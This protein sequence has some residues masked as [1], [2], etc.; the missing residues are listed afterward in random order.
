MIDHPIPRST[1]RLQI[2]SAFTFA[3][4][5]ALV[6]YLAELG[7]SHAYLSPILKARRGS[8]H[9]YDTVDH[10][11][12]S[13]ELGGEEGFRRLAAAL[14]A[15]GM[16]ILLDIVPNHMGVGGDENDLWLDLLEWG[17]ASRYA[18]WFDVNWRP[19][20]PTL[21]GKVLVPFLASSYA[22]AL[23][24]DGLKLRFDA[25]AG[26]FAVWAEGAHKLPLAPRSYLDLLGGSEAP[27]GRPDAESLAAPGEAAASL[28][29][30]MRALPEAEVNRLLAEVNGSPDRLHQLI[31]QQHWR[32]ARFSVAADD[33]NYRRFF[34]VSDLAAVRV[35]RDDVF[36]H[37]H[38][39]PLRLVEEGLVDGLRID[40]IDG[41][42]DPKAYCL[43]LRER[44]ARPIYLVVEKILAPHEQVRADWKVD[45]TTGYEFATAVTQLL[46]DP[47]AE[48]A[49]S[50]TYEEQAGPQPEVAAVEREAKLGIID[51]EMPAELDSLTMQLHRLAGQ[52][53]S[54]ADI[55]RNSLRTALRAFVAALPVYRTYIDE[56]ELDDADRR[57]I[58]VALGEARRAAPAVDPAV[59]DFLERVLIGELHRASSDY[60]AGDVRDVAQR[61][62]Q[63]TGPVMAKGLEDTALYR[64]HRLISHSD[65]GQKPDRFS[66]TPAAF[67]D[68]C[69]AQFSRQPNALLT[70][71]SH[72]TKR[73]EDVRAR[74]VALSGCADA[75]A[76]AVG[77]WKAMLED[78]G[79]PRIDG[80]DRY[81]FLQLLL[82]AWPAELG[83][84]LEPGD[85]A[86]AELRQRLDGAMLKSV[87]EARQR[88]NWSVPRTDYEEAVSRFVEVAL[89]LRGAFLASF[90]KFEQQIGPLGAQNGLIE[91]VLKLTVPGVPDIYQGA[92]FWEQSM[93][94]PDNRRPVDFRRRRDGLDGSI[95]LE[96]LTS[97]WRDGRVKQWVL[98]RLLG[99][100]NAHPALFAAGDY[101]PLAVDDVDGSCLAFTRRHGAE[102]LLVCVRLYPWRSHPWEGASL[103]LPDMLGLWTPVLGDLTFDAA[104]AIIRFNRFP[105]AVAVMSSGAV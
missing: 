43:R 6:P 29:E 5:E 81:H 49:L 98:Q 83:P 75:W 71:S 67:H 47:V 41:L 46:T 77:R 19:S 28:K 87:R 65:V 8:T 34:I 7:I 37:V 10:R 94:D 66:R 88:T 40:H 97:S 24:G 61:I 17:E 3:D 39:V 57:N 16:G 85:D 59:F 84:G 69:R 100:R 13:P 91:L 95:D 44:C 62:Q 68:F 15:R 14:K 99:L 89:E 51:F 21:H 50:R 4:A 93:V 55:T 33:I 60:D 27:S 101:A 9:G 72:D 79:A 30:R 78:A 70:S 42:K 73:G 90:R 105:F 12:I 92:E 48:Q 64:Y 23:A 54:S 53:R 2:S 38:Q 31:E 35:E 104:H 20:E 52:S 96:Q 56:G 36:E 45:A 58:A 11:L 86:L 80:N 76:E 74:V 103:H 102:A 18:E 22:E 1:Y 63:Y 32:P 82:G 25:A 26:E